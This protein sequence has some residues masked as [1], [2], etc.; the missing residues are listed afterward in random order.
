MKRRPRGHFFKPVV[1]DALNAI[2]VF[3][4][5]AIVLQA[6]NSLGLNP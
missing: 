6:L 1:R 5:L 3:L 4:L 2:G